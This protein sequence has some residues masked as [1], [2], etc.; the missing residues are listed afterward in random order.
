MST[1]SYRVSEV[2]HLTNKNKQAM[3]AMSNVKRGEKEVKCV[4]ILEPQIDYVF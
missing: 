1:Y 3:E 2:L 4:L